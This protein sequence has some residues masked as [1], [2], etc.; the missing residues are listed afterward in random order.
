MFVAAA[1]L[2][3]P[4]AN[5]SNESTHDGKVVSIS[6]DKLVMKS[7]DGQEHSHTLAPN[8]KVTCDGNACKAS[9][10]KTGMQIRV[11]TKRDDPRVAIEVESLGRNPLFANTHEGKVVSIAGNKL[12]MSDRQDGPEHSHILAAD[13]NVTCDGK[14]CKASDLKTG[15]TIRVTTRKLDKNVAIRIDAI[16]KNADFARS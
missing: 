2:A 13:A 14:A 5:D 11:T 6:N 16:D 9:D 1:A 7:Q 4:V 3:A 10:L 8:A 15:M 12:V